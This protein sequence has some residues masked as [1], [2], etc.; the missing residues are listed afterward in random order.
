MTS[1]DMAQSGASGDGNP[2]ADFF[3]NRGGAEGFDFDESV[4]E[5]MGNMFGGMGHSQSL[6]GKDVVLNIQISFEESING[7]QRTVKFEKV[8]HCT[9]CKGTKSAPGYDPINCS[10]CGGLGHKTV[11]QG[12]LSIRMEC[13]GCDGSGKIVSNPCFSCAGSGSGNVKQTKNIKVPKGVS[14]GQ[15]LRSAGKVFT[16]KS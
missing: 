4:F 3:R 8:G 16:P 14:N 13:E 5:S 2:F 7:V 6:K 15:R 12:P 10:T 1:D 11:E 9:T